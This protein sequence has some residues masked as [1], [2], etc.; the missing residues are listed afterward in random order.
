MKFETRDACKFKKKEKKLLYYRYE[1][2]VVLINGK[3]IVGSYLFYEHKKNRRF[4]R[5]K[6]S[7]GNIRAKEHREVSACYESLLVI[8]SFIIHPVGEQGIRKTN[9][10]MKEL[11]FRPSF[12][13][14]SL[15]P[16]INFE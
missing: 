13:N 6:F 9:R 5:A 10:K 16:V 11:F 14:D 7:G 1:I 12:R 3:I 8:A 2:H 15:S 4:K